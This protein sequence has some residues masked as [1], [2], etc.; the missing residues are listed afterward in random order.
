MVIIINKNNIKNKLGIPSPY[1]PAI[2]I[3][4]EICQATFEVHSKTSDYISAAFSIFY[5]LSI[6]TGGYLSRFESISEC[7]AIFTNAFM[8][9]AKE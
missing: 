9:V 8:L 4:G 1:Y 2:N 7:V 6:T 5:V 3:L